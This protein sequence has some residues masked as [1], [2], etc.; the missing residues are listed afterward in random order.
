MK[1]IK[2]FIDLEPGKMFNTGILPNS[3][4]GIFMTRDGGFLRWVAIKGYG[5]DWAVYCYWDFKSPGWIKQHG[6]KLHN[7]EHIK[8]CV[9]CDDEMFKLYRF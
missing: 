3:P 9:S 6:D 1:T 8:K 7:V 2:E 4:K 5:N